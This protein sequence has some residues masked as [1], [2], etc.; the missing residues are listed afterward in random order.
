MPPAGFAGVQS[1]GHPGLVSNDERTMALLM[2]LLTLVSGFIGPLIL[3]LV[4]RDESPF[5]D[6]HGKEALNFQ[7]S[8]IFY[9]IGTIIAMLFLIGLLI[10]PILLIVQLLFPILAA[11]AGNR[12]DYYRYPLTLRII[13]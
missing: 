13:T 11:V 7:I 12:G 6:H 9:W 8:L 5:L 2:H 4:K 10:I 1:P 3:W